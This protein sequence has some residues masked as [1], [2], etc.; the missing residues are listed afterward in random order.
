TGFGLVP[1]KSQGSGSAYD[2][3]VQGFTTRY[4]HL[5]YSL[6]YIVTLEELEDNLYEKVSKTRA[7]ALAFSFNQTK[8]NV[9]AALYNNAFDSTHKMGDGSALLEPTT[10]TPT[11]PRGP[12]CSPHQLTSQN[13]P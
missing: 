10:K 11:A 12:T 13:L 5:T 3:E 8:E 2:S 1:V 6:G 4:L 7:S 9:V